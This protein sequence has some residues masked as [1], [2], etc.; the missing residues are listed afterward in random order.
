MEISVAAQGIDPFL[1]RLRASTRQ[2]LV[3]SRLSMGAAAVVWRNRMAL[4]VDAA[5]SHLPATKKE[6]AGKRLRVRISYLTVQIQN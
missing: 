3:G 5:K 1:M 4:V 2:M 6:V